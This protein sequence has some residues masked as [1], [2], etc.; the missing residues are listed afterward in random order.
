MEL[1]KYIRTY[2]IYTYIDALFVC[3]IHIYMYVVNL[4]QLRA[5]VEYLPVINCSLP[6]RKG[7]YGISNVNDL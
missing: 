5:Y 6:A 2:S 1:C 7:A 3:I 4:T